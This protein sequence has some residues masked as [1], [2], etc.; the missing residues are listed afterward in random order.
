MRRVVS[1]ALALSAFGVSTPA[2]AQETFTGVKPASYLKEWRENEWWV[3]A[4]PGETCLSLAQDPGF[5]PIRF[6]GFSQSPGSRLSLVFGTIENARPQTLQMQ[7]NGGGHFDY[8]AQVV[9]VAGEDAY[10]ISFKPNSLSAF[11]AQTII[12]ASANGA[13]V[14][15]GISNNTRSMQKMMGKCAEWQQ[16]H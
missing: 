16:S 1:L 10:V 8:P 11:H 2:R 7:F 6:W 13:V 9:R 3:W 14:F 12:E 4:M 15:Y 5:T